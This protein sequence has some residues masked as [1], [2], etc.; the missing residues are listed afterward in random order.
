[1]NSIQNYPAGALVQVSPGTLLDDHIAKGSEFCIVTRTTKSES[2]Y[3]IHEILFQGKL[4]LIESLRLL[5]VQDVT[6]KTA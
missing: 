6:E 5:P 1:M 2:R 3:A 4:I